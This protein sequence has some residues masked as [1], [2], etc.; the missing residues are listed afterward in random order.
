MVPSLDNTDRPALPVVGAQYHPEGG[1]VHHDAALWG[2]AKACG[3][4]GVDICVGVEVTGITIENGR[5]TGVE[6]RVDADLQS[7]FDTIP[8]QG[9]MELVK[10]RVSDDNVLRLLQRFLDQQVIEGMKH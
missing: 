6:T 1:T 10:G 9:L 2:Y 3:R 5:A 4:L 8:K 7:Y